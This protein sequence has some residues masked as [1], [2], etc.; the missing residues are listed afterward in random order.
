MCEC[1]FSVIKVVLLSV[2]SVNYPI[3]GQSDFSG[4]SL[5]SELISVF[6]A[7]KDFR[8]SLIYNLISVFLNAYLRLGCFLGRTAREFIGHIRKRDGREEKRW[9]CGKVLL[10]DP[11]LACQSPTPSSHSSAFPLH[12]VMKRQIVFFTWLEL[13]EPETADRRLLFGKHPYSVSINCSNRVFFTPWYT[14]ASLD[15]NLISPSLLLFV[16]VTPDFTHHVI[17]DGPK[18]NSHANSRMKRN[19]PYGDIAS[20]RKSRYARQTCSSAVWLSVTFSLTD[21]SRGHFSQDIIKNRHDG[22][23][24][25]TAGMLGWTSFHSAHV[26]IRSLVA[27]RFWVMTNRQVCLLICGTY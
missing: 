12:F 22:F 7:W 19:S 8:Q 25:F 6:E 10:S 23:V 2:Y 24:K 4:N 9:M 27:L 5:I 14:S 13:S 21:V 16:S 17:S 1:R 20:H 3:N 18:T 26:W 15:L 11:P